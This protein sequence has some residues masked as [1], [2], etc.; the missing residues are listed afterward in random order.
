MEP[1]RSTGLLFPELC[2]QLFDGV[3]SIGLESYGTASTVPDPYDSDPNLNKDVEGVPERQD[4]EGAA[5]TQETGGR[6]STQECSS[7]PPVQSKKRK[8]KEA[9]IQ[10]KR[11]L[12]RPF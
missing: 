1:L 9:S 12:K 11:K 6:T 4:T 5:T 2:V 10:I 7:R 3:A 8:A